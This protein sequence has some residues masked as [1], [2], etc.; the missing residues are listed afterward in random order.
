MRS[1]PNTIHG[2]IDEV[3]HTLEHMA[4]RGWKGFDCSRDT[5]LLMETWGKGSSMASAEDSLSQIQQELENC[6]RCALSQSRRRIVIG[7]GNPNADLMF[8]G[9]MPEHEAD[10]TGD[11]FSGPAG[12]LLTRI[13]AAMKLTPKEVYLSTLVKCR[14]PNQRNPLKLE[15]KACRPFLKRQIRVINPKVICSMGSLATQIIL[16]TDRV[17]SQMRGRFH[18]LDDIVVMPT[19]HPEELLR[20]PEKKRDTW[21]DIKKIMRHLNIPVG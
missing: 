19:F 3:I 7:Y 2:I 21:A 20:H 17:V 11:P 1:S 8:V 14:P 6:Q 16:K 15:I 10:M 13:V 4:Q 12:Q 9:T 18:P 5:L